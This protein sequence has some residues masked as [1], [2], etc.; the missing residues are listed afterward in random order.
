[1]FS[2]V[3]ALRLYNQ[4]IQG[5]SYLLSEVERVQLKKSIFKSCCQEQGRV[6]EKA[7]QDDREEMARKELGSGKKTSCVI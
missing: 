3:F 2:V 1:M 5:S 4:R 6:L 7:G